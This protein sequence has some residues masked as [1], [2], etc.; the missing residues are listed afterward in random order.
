MKIIMA[1]MLLM[2]SFSS[3]AEDILFS[4]VEQFVGV[5]TLSD[6]TK[7]AAPIT[8]EEKSYWNL[9][10]DGG[11]NFTVTLH[12]GY[13][14]N[15]GK[16]KRQPDGSYMSVREDGLTYMKIQGKFLVGETDHQP[17]YREWSLYKDCVSQ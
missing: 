13:R 11:D 6:G 2:L 7:L 17:R 4:C 10:R 15:S 16:M 3:R 14:L 5:I 9:V 12:N 8:R 1:F